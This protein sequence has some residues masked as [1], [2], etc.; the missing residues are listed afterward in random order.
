VAGATSSG[1]GLEV[2]GGPC[3][4]VVIERAAQNGILEVR[5]VELGALEVRLDEDGALEM[6]LAEVGA[7]EVRPVEDGV[8]ELRLA[9]V[10]ALQVRPVEDGVLE[11]R[12][13]E[14]GV[15]QV[16]LEVGLPQIVA[17]SASCAARYSARSPPG[18]SA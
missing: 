16:P 11:V 13:G 17:L 7:S 10:G 2:P 15:L 3:R 18:G 14:V 4:S 12:L 6:R 8:L 5:L 9:E 1:F